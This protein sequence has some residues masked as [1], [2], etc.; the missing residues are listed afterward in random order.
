MI[1]K[2]DH[3]VPRNEFSEILTPNGVILVPLGGTPKFH[4]ITV[5]RDFRYN[6]PYIKLHHKKVVPEVGHF[7]VP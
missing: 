2:S 7:G 4:E 6:G 3:F 5:F 1:P